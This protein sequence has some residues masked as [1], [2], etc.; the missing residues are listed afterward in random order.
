MTEKLVWIDAITQR[1]AIR[2]RTSRSAR[3]SE[4]DSKR[5]ASSDV[6]PIVFPS[7]IPDTESDSCTRLEMSAIV[8]WV[9][10]AIRRRSFP[11]RRVRST[12]TGMSANANSASFQ[13]SAS[14]PI[15][16]AATVVALDAIDVAVLVTT[17]WTPPMSFEI[18]D[19][20]SPVRVRVKN[21]SE[22]RCKWR[23]TAARRS[24]MTR[25]PTWLER[26]VWMTP[27]TPV[28]TAIAII[29]PA[30]YESCV[31]SERSIACRTP[32]SRKAGITPSA[33]DR[34]ISASTAASRS[35]YAEKSRPIRRRFALRTAGSSGR[36]G[37]SW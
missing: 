24:C 25:W 1:P 16:V 9:V 26:S 17:L 6:R 14:M 5:S 27:R 11:T 13:L 31:V 3:R 4:S 8:S 32:R 35:L 22:S 20:T 37:G 15:I 28:T 36:T 12:K 21:A 34:T 29:P 23:K 18:R 2:W 30:R 10:F 7:M 19:C 33:A